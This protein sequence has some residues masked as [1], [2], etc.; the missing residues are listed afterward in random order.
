MA[1][2]GLVA[3]QIEEK[4]GTWR[5]AL[6]FFTSSLGGTPLLLHQVSLCA[7]LAQMNISKA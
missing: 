7:L 4:Y 1:L 3:H 6:L 5:I 2:F